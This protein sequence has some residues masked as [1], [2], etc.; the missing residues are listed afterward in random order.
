[1]MSR[2]IHRGSSRL[3]MSITPPCLTRRVWMGRAYLHRVVQEVSR[4]RSNSSRGM[5]GAR[6]GAD[7]ASRAVPQRQAAGRAVPTWRGWRPPRCGSDSVL[8][9]IDKGWVRRGRRV[10]RAARRPRGGLARNVQHL[11]V[12]RHTP[13]VLQVLREGLVRNVQHVDVSRHTPPVLQV[14]R[15][16]LVRN[17]QHEAVA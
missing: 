2:A 15:G 17:V 1:M 12:S 11:D 8:N 10:N 4:L 6:L 7:D 5:H 14:L 3:R 9:C 13:P 16:G